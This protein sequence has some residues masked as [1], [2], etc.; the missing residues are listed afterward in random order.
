MFSDERLR[1]RLESASVCLPALNE[2]D[3]VGPIVARLVR[4]REEGLIDEVI[5]VDGGSV[6]G[7][8]DEARSAGADVYGWA[9]LQP[10]L[11]PLRGKGDSMWRALRV[12]R[13]DLICFLDGDLRSFAEHYVYGLIGPL[14]VASEVDFVKSTFARPLSLPNLPAGAEQGGRVTELLARPML[15]LFY[16]QLAEFRQPLSGQIA[17]RRWLLE[18]IP[19][20]TGYA[21]DVGL[22]IDVYKRV[23]LERMAQVDL[24]EL[25]TVHQKLDGLAIMAQE[26]ATAIAVRAERDRIVTGVN[27]KEYVRIADDEVVVAA[28]ELIDRPAIALLGQ[29]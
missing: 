14:V 9:A 24:G 3:T 13:G 19:F 21:V 28:D 23:G 29:D 12:A 27:T 6:D 1:A 25:I 16:P 5:V 11:G 8:P 7:T 26:V 15:S 2:V 22:L 4:M 18:S 20:S 17:A 10:D